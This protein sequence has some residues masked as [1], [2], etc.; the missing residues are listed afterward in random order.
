MMTN[1]PVMPECIVF[2]EEWFQVSFTG[3]QGSYQRM[4]ERFIVKLDAFVRERLAV[5][6]GGSEIESPPRFGSPPKGEK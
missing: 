1:H 5:A 3:S 2:A 6:N 4:M